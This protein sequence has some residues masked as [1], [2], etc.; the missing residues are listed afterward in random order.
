MKRLALGLLL[1]LLAPAAQAADLVIGMEQVPRSLDPHAGSADG[2]A[3]LSHLYDPLIQQDE[4]L[5]LRPALAE[6]WR[7]IDPATW[8]I[9]LR[10]DAHF[11]DGTPVTAED[12]VFSIARLRHDATGPGWH[13]A[14]LFRIIRTEI[15]DPGM[16]RLVTDTPQPLLPVDLAALFIVSRASPDD[17]GRQIG[18]GPYL[19]ESFHPGESLALRA[20]PSYWGAAPA[21]NQV[22]LRG[23]PAESDR[24]AALLD[25]DVDLIAAVP[26]REVDRIMAQG[27][28]V[29]SIR[30]AHT[31]FIAFDQLHTVTP[32]VS[33]SEG[34]Q[35][36]NPFHDVRVRRALSLA[37]DRSVLVGRVMA[38]HATAASQLVPPGSPGASAKLPEEAA[39]PTQARRLLAEAGFPDGLILTLHGPAGRRPGDAETLRAV[40]EMWS[41]VGVRT[42]PVALPWAI[43][44]ITRGRNEYSVY[45]AASPGADPMRTLVSVLHTPDAEAR[46]GWR[47]PGFYSNPKVDDLLMQA[48]ANF[49]PAARNALLATAAE[50]AMVDQP[51]IPLYYPDDLWAFGPRVTGF[52]PD[53]RGR[54][55]AMQA[56][57]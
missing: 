21:W 52:R 11:Q 27:R 25:G 12:V 57:K 45:Q 47:N 42:N 28:H 1:L 9:R 55:T 26:P 54:T 35:I 8:E 51:V 4:T 18:S 44:A 14:A 48:A 56:L 6:S 49:D 53:P 41:R 40:A 36:G 29:A 10:A 24:L 15:L 20:S 5:A 38:G 46:L 32:F 30:A 22:E 33:D 13:R 3:V 7:L 19:V 37:I 39:D 2:R 31:S 34:K 43:Y 50:T 17:P 16:L 23:I